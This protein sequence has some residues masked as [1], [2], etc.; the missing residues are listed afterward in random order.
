MYGNNLKACREELSMTQ[1]ELGFVFGLSD[2]T[3][4]SWENAHEFIPLVKLIKFC[5]LYNYS[6]DYVVG[7]TRKN[8]KYGQFKTDKKAIAQRLKEFRTNRNLTQQMLADECKISQTT[9]SGYETGH[10]L[11]NTTNLYYICKTYNISM[12]YFMGRTNNSKIK[13]S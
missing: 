9:Y 5:N 12:D 6:L 13:T 11:I 2:S 4:R 1:K 3:I 7:F 10:Y 8:I